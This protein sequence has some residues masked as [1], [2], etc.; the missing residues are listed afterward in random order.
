VFPVLFAWLAPGP[1]Q[2]TL[3]CVAAVGALVLWTHRGNIG[4]LLAGS[5]RRL[6]ERR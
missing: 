5:E 4:R 6:G 3:A 1:R 2:T